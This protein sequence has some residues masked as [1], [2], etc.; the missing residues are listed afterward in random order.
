MVIDFIN[1]FLGSLP[2]NFNKDTQETR[3]IAIAHISGADVECTVDGTS[4]TLKRG[5]LFNIDSVFVLSGKT[6]DEVATE[7]TASGNYVATV[8]NH[9]DEN[10]LRLLDGTF[11]DGILYAFD[12]INYAIA[13]AFAIEL[14]QISQALLETIRQTVIQSSTGMVLDY[15]G[16]FVGLT[17]NASESDPV[18]SQRVIDAISQTR[19]NNKSIE[20]SL[21]KLYGIQNWVIDCTPIT[22]GA[23]SMWWPTQT[24]NDPICDRTKPLY[25]TVELDLPCT[26]KVCLQDWFITSQS[27]SDVQK[28][29]QKVSYSKASGTTFLFHTNDIGGAM[30]MN[31]PF[32]P[33]ADTDLLPIF[34]LYDGMQDSDGSAITAPC[35]RSFWLSAEDHGSLLTLDETTLLELSENDLLL[36]YFME[37]EKFCPIV[38]ENGN[39]I[40]INIGMELEENIIA[41]RRDFDRFLAR[42]LNV[43]EKELLE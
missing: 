10:A 9:A 1:S 17:R 24:A 36:Y 11:G 34:T 43:Y 33:I 20:I 37:N 35:K 27:L 25:Q 14:A 23:M 5:D 22:S 18:F 7:I 12:N 31:C 4:L 2:P 16:T 42:G 8:V 26:F 28:I 40:V 6:I 21:V 41:D 13:K 32:T 39:N 29:V 30:L 38:D 19:A 15:Y 3:A